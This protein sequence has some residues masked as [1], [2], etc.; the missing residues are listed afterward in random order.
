MAEEKNNL[1]SLLGEPFEPAEEV[2][3]NPVDEGEWLEANPAKV[4]HELAH[5]IAEETGLEV[6]E[7]AFDR[8]AEELA[9][10]EWSTAT[11][12]EPLV[13]QHA[14]AAESPPR[15]WDGPLRSPQKTIFDETF[16][17][18]ELDGAMKRAP[19]FTK[20]SGRFDPFEL[21]R[22]RDM[23]EGSHYSTFLKR[24][25]MTFKDALD[26]SIQLC[27]FWAE[28]DAS[29]EAA[30]PEE[31]ERLKFAIPEPEP[32]TTLDDACEAARLAWK[33]AVAKRN[34]AMEQWNAY[35]AE[36]RLRYQH[37]KKAAKKR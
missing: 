22:M 21:D 12:A 18:E 2:P 5:Q 24:S 29:T 9:D 11:P 37:A 14:A 7:S 28:E 19:V 30:R 35:V 17:Q 15:V 3:Q 25:I 10:S 31:E 6:D 26:H 16:D 13:E 36:L 34:E 20:M 27:R 4:L 23:L 32:D 8:A 33:E 1:E